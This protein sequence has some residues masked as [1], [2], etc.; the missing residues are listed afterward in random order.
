MIEGKTC[1]MPVLRIVDSITELGVHDK[2]CIAVSGSHGGLSSARY[3]L[4]SQP[5][6][7]VFNDAGVG[8][9]RAG[10]AALA[11]LQSH[12]LAAC[13]VAHN[14]ARIGE[15]GSTLASGV[16]NA[17]NDAAKALGIQTGWTCQDAVD[18][19]LNSQQG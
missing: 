7:S 8:L 16:V 4:A 19:L 10:L 2:G 15:A 17:A 13:T 9:N 3:A 5:L 12:S 14:T 6:L 1:A 11:F 18:F